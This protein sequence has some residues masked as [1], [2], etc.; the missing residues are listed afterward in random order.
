MNAFSHTATMTRLLCLC[1]LAMAAL[2]TTAAVPTAQTR[3]LQVTMNDGR[4]TIVARNV[5][6]REVLQE[7]A[8]V[9]KTTIVNAE[10]LAGPP[11]TLHLVNSTER[12]ALDILLRSAAGYLAVPRA[13][14]NPGTSVYDRIAILATSRA[15]AAT[16]MAMAAPPPAP[17]QA[18]IPNEALPAHGDY[19]PDPAPAPAAAANPVSAFT[20][21]PEP[22]AYQVPGEAGVQPSVAGATAASPFPGMV[23]HLEGAQPRDFDFNKMMG[24]LN[25]GRGTAAP[26]T[27]ATPGIT[28]RP[29][30][31]N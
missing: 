19:S 17:M 14:S 9:G 26:A 24:S 3:D 10:K 4:V 16:A 22:E 15:P 2:A 21:A 13:E 1:C 12:D 27:S 5:S 18:A 31:G 11:L 20:A 7:W 29:G 30:G 23:P 28:T 6:L 8:R 25:Q